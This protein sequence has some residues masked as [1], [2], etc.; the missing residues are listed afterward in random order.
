MRQT[1]RRTPHHQHARRS[2]RDGLPSYRDRCTAGEEGGSCDDDVGGV[3]GDGLA[4]DEEGFCWRRRK[5]G[6]R[7]RKYCGDAIDEE[8]SR[9]AEADGGAGKGDGGVTGMESCASEGET[10]WGGG[11]G[12]TAYCQDTWGRIGGCEE[13][14]DIVDIEGTGGSETDRRAGD[15]QGGVTGMEGCARDRKSCRC[16]GKGLTTNCEN[17]WRSGID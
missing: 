17:L 15:G 12:L 7:R 1:D 5:G 10:C 4:V 13:C 9:G 6:G 11:D 3:D 16:G 8:G 2:E 14:R